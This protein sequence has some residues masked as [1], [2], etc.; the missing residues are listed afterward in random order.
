VVTAA[1]DLAS[2]TLQTHPA[3]GQ[4]RPAKSLASGTVT[5]EEPKE[6]RRKHAEGRH[7]DHLS[8]VGEGPQTAFNEFYLLQRYFREHAAAR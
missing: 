7:S 5:S 1:G 4:L 6:T 8:H 2:P 3:A